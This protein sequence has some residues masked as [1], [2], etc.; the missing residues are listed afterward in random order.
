MFSKVWNCEY[1]V[2]AADSV[3]TSRQHG[4]FDEGVVVSRGAGY[5]VSKNIF[6][7][8]DKTDLVMVNKDVP[9]QVCCS[10]LYMKDTPDVQW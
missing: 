6:K 3:P 9:T 10:A 8:R 7:E 4:F 2:F 5:N 1:L